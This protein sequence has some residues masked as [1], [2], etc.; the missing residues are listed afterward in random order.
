MQPM[1]MY[2]LMCGCAV[3]DDNEAIET[4]DLSWNHLRGKGAVCLAMGLQVTRGLGSAVDALV[5]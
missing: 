4:L 2:R 1:R 3:V 5:R